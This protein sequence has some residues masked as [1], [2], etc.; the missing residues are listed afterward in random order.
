MKVGVSLFVSRKETSLE[1]RLIA[2]MILSRNFHYSIMLSLKRPL[3][4]MKFK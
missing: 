1:D 3:F 2:V 4:T